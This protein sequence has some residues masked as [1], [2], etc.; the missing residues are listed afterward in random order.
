[1]HISGH[2]DFLFA[3]M[4]MARFCFDIGSAVHLYTKSICDI[5]LTAKET[6]CNKHQ[7]D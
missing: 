3:C 7:I 6:C 1:M 5:T 2:I 4:I